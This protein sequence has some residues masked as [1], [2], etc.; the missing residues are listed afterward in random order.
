MADGIV[1]VLRVLANQAGESP[2]PW[3][4]G[5][6]FARYV[7]GS[8][9]KGEAAIDWSDPVAQ[10]QFLQ[11]VV[12][13]ADRLLR[14]VRV[15]RAGLEPGSTE[16]TALVEAAGVLSRVLVQDLERR[17]D[18]AAL[19]DGVAP[20]RLVSVHD[21]EMR[22]GRKSARKRF[23]GHKASLAVDTESQLIT[24]VAVLPGNAA[25]HDGALGLV[26]QTEERTGCAVEET[27][28]DCAYGDGATRQ[29]FADAGRRLITKVP[30]STNQGAFPKT[31]F[32]LDLEGETCTCPAG[33]TT[34]NLR[35]AGQG[36]RAFTFPA[37]VCAA[38]P[39]RAQCVRG[40]GGRTIAV[41]P[42][43]ALL[44]AARAFQASPAF[45]EVRARRQVVEHRIARLMQLGMRQAR[46]FGRPKTLF[47]LCVAAAVANLTLLANRSGAAALAAGLGA[48]RCALLL[49]CWS[50][51][52]PLQGLIFA[53]YPAT[54]GR[55]RRSAFARRPSSA[56]SKMPA[57]RPDS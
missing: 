24:A 11:T 8:S 19:R 13:D 26:Q 9:L 20:D 30:A 5:A 34:T 45:R 32:V 52:E 17:A 55:Y 23:D 37:A 31:A 56:R 50:L 1:A 47:Q 22:H 48:A 42:Q 38:C 21:P 51:L 41:H 36:A 16:E 43:E 49:A 33:E 35:S 10:R 54:A 25:D 12:A 28:G 7:T 6:G 2:E 14:D 53:A 4:T 3:A 40:A 57:S 39:L 29:E 27:Y 44:Q 18:G 15:V 46:Y